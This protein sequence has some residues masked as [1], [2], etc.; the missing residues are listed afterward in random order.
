M[1]PQYRP[2]GHRFGVGGHRNHSNPYSHRQ[3][4]HL[5]R[6]LGRRIVR[7]NVLSVAHAG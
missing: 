3:M 5:L 4:L 1:R 2:I 6:Q 7:V